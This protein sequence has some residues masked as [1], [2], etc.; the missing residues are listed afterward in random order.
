MFRSRLG[1][2]SL[3]AV[4]LGLMAMSASSAQAGLSWLVL[5]AAHT[6]A[7]EIQAPGGVINLLVPV[8]GERESAHLSLKAKLVNTEVIFTCNGLTTAGIHLAQEGKLTEGFKATFSGCELYSGPGPLDGLIACTV[9]TAGSPSGTLVTNELKGSL[10]LN[11]SEVQMLI[12]P[13]AAGGSLIVIRLEGGGC[14]YPESNQLKGVLYL[15]DT[16]AT[17]H[18]EKHLVVQGPTAGQLYFG[19]HSNEQLEKTKIN[20]SAWFKLGGMTHAGLHWAAMDV[21]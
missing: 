20:G 19:N 8:T 16:S 13:R 4:V 3:S 21:P 7:T 11:E 5:N 2:L 6:I 17:T 14:G 15:K 12:E 10:V 9:K 18:G 1:L